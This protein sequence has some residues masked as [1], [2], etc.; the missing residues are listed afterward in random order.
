MAGGFA[1]PGGAQPPYAEYQ[2]WRPPGAPGGY[3]GPD[4]YADIVNGGD[5][6]YVIHEGEPGAPS[7]SPP[8]PGARGQGL[9]EWPAPHSGAA[10]PAG[11][12][13]RGRAITAGQ[14]S[15]AWPASAAAPVAATSTADASPP[16][17]AARAAG[18]HV[19][20]AAPP[21]AGPAVPA[22]AKPA[23][24]A[25][26]EV[27]PALA[28]GPDD[29]AYGP[30]GPGWY[31]RDEERAPRA[32]EAAATAD[33]GASR[34]A[35]GPFEPL[36]PGDQEEA[37]HADYQ[38]DHQSGDADAALDDSDVGPLDTE[39]SEYAPI[40]EY[41]PIDDEMSEL[42]GSG[43]P[44]DPEEGTLGQIK[45]LY[46]RAETVSQASLDRHFD[47]LLERQRQLIS[48]YFKESG[49]LGLAGTVTPEPVTVTDP[50]VS[51]G[52]DTAESLAGL[53]GELRGAQ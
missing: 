14:A 49:G 25:A 34:A 30:P 11:G 23:P 17:S 13:V 15:A 52:F 4:G 20:A 39:I 38:S 3:P 32:G 6:A 46:E 44:T 40:S 22:D 45:D 31:Q 8:R 24:A 51:L 53:R 16:R 27:D 19:P 47:Q 41:E 36:R 35:R 48:E 12:T 18:A 37:G 10:Q 2:A 26:P 5:Y 33:T 28:Y 42:L 7:Q 29:P 21:P 1:D 43:E 9:G 50:T